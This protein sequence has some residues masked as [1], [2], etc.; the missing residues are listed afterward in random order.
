LP[1]AGID[2]VING[3]ASWCMFCKQRRGEHQDDDSQQQQQQKKQPGWRRRGFRRGVQQQ[4]RSTDLPQAC[5]SSSCRAFPVS[6]LLLYLGSDLF[7]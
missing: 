7:A 4:P 3:T 1:R 5:A 6:V 2:D